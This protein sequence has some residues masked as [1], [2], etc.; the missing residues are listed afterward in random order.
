MVLLGTLALPAT[1]LAEP[2][3]NDRRQAAQECRTERGNTATTRNAFRQRYGENEKGRHA[4]RNCRAQRAED[5]ESER[6]S[7]RSQAVQECR[8]LHPRGEG[9]PD[10]KGEA[11]DFG[12]CVSERAKQKNAEADRRDREEIKRRHRAAAR[13]G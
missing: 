3:Q 10:N 1:A 2:N 9:K 11:N 4:F 13:R 8:E 5:E 7:A 12:K 6:R